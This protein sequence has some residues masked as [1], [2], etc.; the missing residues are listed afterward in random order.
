[1]SKG[2]YRASKVALAAVMLALVTNAAGAQN[3]MAVY[4]ER[5]EIMKSLFP[6][7]YRG[8]SQ[9]ARGE[10]TDIASIPAK[11]QEAV[12]Q[13]QKFATLFPAGSGRE[14]VPETRSKPE[15]WSQKAAFEA[16]NTKLIVETQKLGD[17]AKTGNVDAV[18]AQFAAVSEACGGCHGSG[19]AG[20]TFRYEAP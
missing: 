1:M 6:T 4:K 12:A 2:L 16:A 14:A 9:V 3:A 18:K 10:S 19:K 15:I 7:Y 8:F 17:I 5:Q 13:L 11:A 20:G